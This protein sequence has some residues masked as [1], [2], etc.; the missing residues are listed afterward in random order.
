ML[1]YSA[2]IDLHLVYCLSIRCAACMRRWHGAGE[3]LKVT[4]SITDCQ[5]APLITFD[6][7]SYTAAIV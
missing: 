1:Y 3:G 4:N 6:M 5:E 2:V 7:K